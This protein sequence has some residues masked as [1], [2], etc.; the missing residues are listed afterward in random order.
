MMNAKKFDSLPANLQKVLRDEGVKI[1]T[2][3]YQVSRD[4]EDVDRDVFA[5]SGV[6]VTEFPPQV[7]AKL[8]KSYS[9]GI[10]AI[11]AKST[12]ADVEAFYQVAKSANMLAE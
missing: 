5:K 7:A 8:S 11:A 9:D 1:E 6:K 2:I 12:P 10:H 3:G 4:L